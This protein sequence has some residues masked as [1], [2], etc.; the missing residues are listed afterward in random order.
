MN[1]SLRNVMSSTIVKRKGT[2]VLRELIK[3]NMANQMISQLVDFMRPIE[4]EL[5]NGDIQYDAKVYVFTEN[6]MS[7]YTESLEK[8]WK[9]KYGIK[10]YV[11]F[12]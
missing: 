1:P 5:E 8:S 11:K 2:T 3:V 12:K 6:Q 9:S 10:W 7:A 4:S